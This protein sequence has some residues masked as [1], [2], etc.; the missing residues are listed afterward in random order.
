MQRA[1]QRSIK[2]MNGP[3]VVYFQSNYCSVIHKAY[4]VVVSCV[5]IHL[6]FHGSKIIFVRTWDLI[7]ENKISSFVHGES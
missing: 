7:L 2:K 1:K 5:S 3:Y 4:L 6:R